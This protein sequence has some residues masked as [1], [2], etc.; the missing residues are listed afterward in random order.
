M[1]TCEVPPRKGLS[2][3]L[4]ALS[5]SGVLDHDAALEK[6]RANPVGFGEVPSGTCRDPLREQ[7]L[8]LGVE[9][10][11][12]TLPID[13]GQHPE[14][15]VGLVDQVDQLLLDRRRRGGGIEQPVEVPDRA[16]EM[17]HRLRD[18][19]VVVH[20]LGK[21]GSRG[22]RPRRGPLAAVT[23]PPGPAP[24]GTLRSS[25]MAWAKAA[26]AAAALVEIS[27][28]PSPGLRS[29]T[30]SRNSVSRPTASSAARSGSS[31]Q[32]RGRP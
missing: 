29:R 2:G 30:R 22:R 3:A 8:L 28:P 19:E 7:L 27:S 26:A 1:S 11:P 31:S 20:G 5:L 24:A 6:L 14:D 12:G 21:C 4:P 17:A 25:A 9:S 18:V 10:R 13:E 16:E 32:S 15:V 23:R